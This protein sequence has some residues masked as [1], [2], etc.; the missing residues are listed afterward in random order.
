MTPEYADRSNEELTSAFIVGTCQ[1]FPRSSFVYSDHMHNMPP[2]ES[3]GSKE[4]LILCGSDAEFYIRPINTCIG[5]FDILVANI[6]ELVFDRDFPVFPGDMSGFPDKV[7][8]FEIEQYDRYPGFVRLRIWGKMTF[9]WKYNKYELTHA[10]NTNNNVLL[11]LRIAASRYS[12]NH[13]IGTLPNVICGPAIK[14][15][16][17][18]H[19]GFYDGV[20]FVKCLW[21]PQ[22]PKEAQ[23]WLS[24]PRS[25]GWPTI[26]TIVEVMQNGCHVVYVQHRACRNDKL[27]WRLSFSLA[28]VTLLMSW[29]PKQQ[30]VYHLLRFFA[31]RQLFQKDY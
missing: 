3:P 5:D 7:T 15:R 25:N 12:T 10:A 31:K 14:Q 23:V 9:N 11:D 22:W 19:S 4:Y 24:R 27:Q 29:S 21:C 13:E 6:D 30:I 18:K 17:E 20:D 8:C 1:L 26:D 16:I 28:E 2:A